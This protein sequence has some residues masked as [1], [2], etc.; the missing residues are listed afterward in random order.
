MKDPLIKYKLSPCKGRVNVKNIKFFEGDELGIGEI[1]DL[2]FVA[3]GQ[4][5]L[6]G[7]DLSAYGRRKYKK[8]NI[9]L[10]NKIIDYCNYKGVH[11]LQNKKL[12]GMYLKTIAFLP[13]NYKEA[14]KLMYVLWYPNRYDYGIKLG[15]F[16]GYSP[17]NIM[18]FSGGNKEDLEL[19]K[20]EIKDMKITLEDLQK[21]H[22]I[23]YL[24]HIKKL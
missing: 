7:L 11:L 8:K 22:K 16:F 1:L 24:D 21:D 6:A 18:Y 5:K 13:K 19:A 9:E 2:Y 14:L 10:I 4:K 3:K 12:V 23:V 15:L 17:K 20:K